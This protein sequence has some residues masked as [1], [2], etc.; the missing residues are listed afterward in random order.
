MN[1]I[2]YAGKVILFAASGIAAL[3][4]QVGIA[5]MLQHDRTYAF[6]LADDADAAAQSQTV[7]NERQQAIDNLLQTLASDRSS[8]NGSAPQKNT[9]NNATGGISPLDLDDNSSSSTGNSDPTDTV[10]AID[11]LLDS[12]G[13]NSTTETEVDAIATEEIE[14][15]V[16]VSSE[17]I[18]NPGATNPLLSE[19][20]T[21]AVPF[22]FSSSLG[23]GLVSLCMGGNY[24]RRRQKNT[25][26]ASEQT[27]Q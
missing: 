22:N 12:A 3:A 14:E 13:G 19:F 2:S 8:N 16:Q 6:D 15:I 1:Q 23:L 17:L 5:G 27:C 24:L 26:L 11:S 18:N 21:V 4:I 10:A 20:N 25:N 9:N 7:L